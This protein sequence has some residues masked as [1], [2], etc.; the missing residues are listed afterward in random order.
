MF[1]RRKYQVF[2]YYYHVDNPDRWN[3][4]FSELKE[5]GF[6]YLVVSEGFDLRNLLTTDS[7]KEQLFRFLDAVNSQ[8]LSCILN[9]GNPRELYILPDARRWRIDYIRHV[10]ETLGDHPALYALMLEASPNGGANAGLDRWKILTAELEGRIESDNLTGDGYQHA[11]KRW[12]MEQYTDYIGE[13]VGVIKKACPRL[14]TTISFCMDA[15]FPNQA[16]VHFQ[17]VARHLDFVIIDAGSGWVGDPNEGRYL[18]RFVTNVATELVNK[19]VWVII[20]SH[21]EQSRYQP[22]L[23]D[24]WEWT[25]QVMDQGAIGVG[26]RGWDHSRWSDQYPV[27]GI[28]LAERKRACWETILSLSQNAAESVPGAVEN[29]TASQACL[30]SYDAFINKLPM[31]DC[32]VPNLILGEEAGFPLAYATDTQIM[33][34]KGLGKQKV[35]F[36]TPCPSVRG[37]IVDRLLKFM[38]NGGWIIASADDFA[39][40]EQIMPSDARSRLFGIRQESSIFHDDRILLSV[41][42]KHLPE[43]TSLAAAWHRSRLTECDDYVRTLARW[44]DKSPAI[45]IMPHGKGGALYIGTEPFR[46]ALTSENRT[47]WR[48]FLQAIADPNTLKALTV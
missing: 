19:A 45:L 46:A 18:H 14:K 13:I 29:K 24:I 22:E 48:R 8:G 35:L 26:W 17:D 47:D 4:D 3:T 21:V 12:Q 33:D 7:E 9:I 44:S 11:V 15:L 2:T 16:L 1:S 32:F 10:T 36:T 42:F 31:A 27:R 38:N 41:G 34:G 43:G 39:T 20:G 30:L 5:N 6:Q 25:Q 37:E 28:P 40:N 23:R